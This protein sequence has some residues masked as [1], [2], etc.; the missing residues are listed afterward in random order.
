[1]PENVIYPAAF[2]ADAPSDVE[3]TFDNVKPSRIDRIRWLEFLRQVG[4][5]NDDEG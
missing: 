4:W 3:L 5:E 1:M 2:H